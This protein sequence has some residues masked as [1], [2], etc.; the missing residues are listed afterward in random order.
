[1]GKSSY[2]VK[3]MPKKAVPKRALSR[4]ELT[5]LPICL[6]PKKPKTGEGTLSLKAKNGQTI[7]RSQ[8]YKTDAG[9]RNGIRSVVANAADSEVID[10]AE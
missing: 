2:K 4:S 7:G 5:L 3:L 8:M 1:M 6:K 10:L 9:L